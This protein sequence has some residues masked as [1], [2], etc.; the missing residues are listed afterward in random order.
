M[1]LINYVKLG[2]SLSLYVYILNF[3]GEAMIPTL[4]GNCE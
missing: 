2:V 3:N 4:Q 1:L